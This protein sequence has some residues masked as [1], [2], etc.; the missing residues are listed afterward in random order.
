M[1]YAARATGRLWSSIF[2]VSQAAFMAWADP[3][4][5]CVHTTPP[6]DMSRET[7]LKEEMATRVLHTI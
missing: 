2:A 4:P 3:M 1:T 6:K 7:Q 5:I